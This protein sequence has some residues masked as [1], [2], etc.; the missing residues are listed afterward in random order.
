MN[1]WYNGFPIIH[2]R[3]GADNGLSYWYDGFP[4]AGE[5]AAIASGGTMRVPMWLFIPLMSGTVTPLNNPTRMTQTGRQVATQEAA[6]FAR[7]TQRGRNAATQEAAPFARM[8]Q[9]A[10]QVI[11]PFTCVPVPPPT[12]S[13]PDSLGPVAGAADG[14]PTTLDPDATDATG[15]GATID[16]DAV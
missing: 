7:M 10:R 16:P 4:L 14:C 2:V 11:Y 13:C 8:T 3:T 6:P 5:A 15:C 1:Y 12:P 9:M